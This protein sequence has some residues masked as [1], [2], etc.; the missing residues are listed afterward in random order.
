MKT[1]VCISLL[2]NDAV[3]LHA[4]ESPNIDNGDGLLVIAKMSKISGF[5]R[6]ARIKRIIERAK[7]KNAV[8]LVETNTDDYSQLVEP[9]KLDEVCPQRTR[10]YLS[11]GLDLYVEKTQG[12]RT[13]YRRGDIQLDKSLSTYWMDIDSEMFNA[14]Q[15]E[16]GRVR[17]DVNY[18]DFTSYHRAILLAVLAAYDYHDANQSFYDQLLGLVGFDADYR[19][20]TEAERFMR[21][22]SGR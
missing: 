19:E 13:Q 15:D 1:I 21:K 8:V 7:E 11:L 14:T 5:G 16:R 22:F 17:Y 2:G 12:E 10:S 20:E 9:F 18:Q 3:E 4:V 6:K